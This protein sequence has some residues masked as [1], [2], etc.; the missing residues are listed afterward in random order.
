VPGK[1][2]ATGKSVKGIEMI[3]DELI[4][5]C[6]S[7]IGGYKMACTRIIRACSNFIEDLKRDDMK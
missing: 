2:K 1:N 4:K 6:N 5:Y 3:R 7:V